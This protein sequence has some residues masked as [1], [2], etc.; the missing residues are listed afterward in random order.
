MK[1][2]LRII[3]LIL[4]TKMN[5]QAQEALPYQE[6][7]QHPE[8]YSAG[9]VMGRMV[10][11]L[12]FRYYWATEGVREED[13]KYRPSE[14]GRTLNETLDHIYGLSRVIVNAPQSIVNGGSTDGSEMTFK[15]KRAETLLNFQKASEL[16]KS[17]G[18][19]EMENYKIL[20]KRDENLSE[21]PFWNMINGP[22]ADAIWH[23]GQVVLLRRAAGNPINP[24]VSVFTGRL[25]E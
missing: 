8:N 15:E 19:D 21:F 11:G 12:G 5:I 22:I 7:P 20:F 3:I 2:P 23:T 1:L 13:L 10:D 14:E 9:N 16:M 4:I 25:R 6:I 24:K 18:H 17:G